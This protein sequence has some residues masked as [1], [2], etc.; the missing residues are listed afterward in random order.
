MVGQLNVVRQHLT[1]CQVFSKLLKLNWSSAT[2]SIRVLQSA[3]AACSPPI[4]LSHKS[5]VRCVSSFLINLG[6]ACNSG[7]LASCLM[8]SQATDV[9]EVTSYCVTS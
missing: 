2:I 6:I 1:R 4:N 5:Q 9:M 7:K 8:V 3:C